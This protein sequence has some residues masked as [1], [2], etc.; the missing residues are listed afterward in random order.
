MNS[1]VTKTFRNKFE[2]LPPEVRQLAAK[3]YRLWRSNPRHPSLHFKQVGDFWSV[4][5][6]RSYRALGRIHEGRMVWFWIGH[7]SVYDRLLS[8]D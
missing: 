2:A 4:R 1:S 7:H 3:N 8:G 5:V 6:G